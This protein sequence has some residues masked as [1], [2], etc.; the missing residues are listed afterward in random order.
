[1]TAPTSEE[2]REVAVRLRDC[3]R[4]VNGTLDFAMY[5][6]HWVGFDGVTDDEGNH[7][8]VAAD[9]KRAEMTLERL[10]DLIDPTCHIG[11]DDWASRQC[12]GTM[13]SCDRCGNAFPVINGPYQY[14]PCCGARGVSDD[15]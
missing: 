10:A 3:A 11:Y 8:S 14:C 4:D 2:R 12:M 15:D 13:L 9:R 6:S 7:F 1:M 5:L